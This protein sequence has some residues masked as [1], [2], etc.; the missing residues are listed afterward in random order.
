MMAVAI[1]T[2]DA[3]RLPIINELGVKIVSDVMSSGDGRDL[4]GQLRRSLPGARSQVTDLGA[5]AAALA[6]K[7]PDFDQ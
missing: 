2:A 4:V 5:L 6:R 1:V 3:V 7:A